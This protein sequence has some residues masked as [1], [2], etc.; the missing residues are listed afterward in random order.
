LTK[1]PEPCPLCGK[2]SQLSYEDIVPTWARKGVVSLTSLGP[3]DQ[4]PRRIKMRI[5]IN[6]NSSLGRAFENDCSELLKPML[7]GSQVILSQRQQIHISCWIIKTSL[8]MN[9]TGL[10][11][12]HPDHSLAISIVRALVAERIPPAKTLVR[13]FTRD[14]YGE[15]R[16]ELVSSIIAPPT[17]FWSV[18]TIGY[19]GWEMA[20]GPTGPIL[21]YQSKDPQLPGSTEIWPPRKREVSWP[22][23]ILSQVQPMSRTSA[24]HILQ[25]PSLVM[26][27]QSGIGGS[28]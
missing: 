8:L 14:I 5:C 24:Q 7:H 13:I 25:Q 18:T 1:Y 2:R 9:L 22:A 19:L 27:R 15:D 17:T 4:W 3:R 10:S 26:R 28:W 12:S 21:E 16:P 11:Q 20:I 23:L 6:C